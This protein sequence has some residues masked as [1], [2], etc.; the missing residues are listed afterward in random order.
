MKNILLVSSDVEVSSIFGLFFKTNFK[1]GIHICASKDQ[2]VED[3]ENKNIDI[4]ITLD[5]KRNQNISEFVKSHLNT[6]GLNIPTFS[7]GA[8]Y[9]TVDF[10][11]SQSQANFSKIG[12]K[13]QDV[14]ELE[15]KEAYQYIPIQIENFY[16]LKSPNCDI[17]IKI[18]KTDGD[19]FVKRINAGDAIDKDSVKKYQDMNLDF[20]YVER[21][22]FEKIIDQILSETLKGIVIA[23]KSKESTIE[24]TG[25]SFEITQNI[26]DEFGV[27]ASTVRVARAT[28]KSILNSVSSNKKLS[29]LLKEVLNNEA[30]YSFKRSFL[31]TLFFNEIA[32]HLGWGKGNQLNQTIEKFAFVSF[33]HDCYLRDEKLLR[34][35]W[36][37]D[38]DATNF[39]NAEYELLDMHANKAAT[40]LQQIPNCPSDVDV[41]IRQHHGTNNGVG[42]ADKLTVSI[43]PIS[44]VFI[45]IEAF[46]TE[47]LNTLYDKKK[48]NIKD[49]FAILNERFTLSSYNKILELL[50]NMVMRR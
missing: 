36:K 20:F 3:L 39:T 12:Q 26:L 25:D 47:I 10:I 37:D 45:V 42:F 22:D 23:N 13:L 27:R 15:Q 38:L 5:A 43:S 35:N 33:F 29:A 41:I 28:I 19:Q 7:I 32:P 1:V 31:N 49:V 11:T 34:I 21:E 44:V 9:L 24:V 8:E 46:S 30:S 17:Y 14:I 16:L 4:I 18:Q 6:N 40:L 48:L 2:F 50:K